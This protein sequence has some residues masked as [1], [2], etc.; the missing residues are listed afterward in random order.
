SDPLKLEQIVEPKNMPRGRQTSLPAQ[1][2]DTMMPGATRRS[3]P[4]TMPGWGPGSIQ[5]NSPPVNRNYR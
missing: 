4:G 3:V 1:P 5:K 2:T